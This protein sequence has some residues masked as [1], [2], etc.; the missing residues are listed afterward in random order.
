M[1]VAAGLAASNGAARRLLDQGGAS[2]NKHRLTSQ[3]RYVGAESV[4]L[5]GEYVIV[6]KGRRDYAVLRVIR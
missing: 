1:L 3:E 5:S 4:L 2:V 6:G